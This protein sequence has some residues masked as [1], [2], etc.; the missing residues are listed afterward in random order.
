MDLQD[1][2]FDATPVNQAFSRFATAQRRF[3]NRKW[4]FHFPNEMGEAETNA[5]QLKLKR[6]TRFQ[7]FHFSDFGALRDFEIAQVPG[8]GI[9]KLGFWN[10]EIGA[11]P[12]SKFR[13][14]G[15]GNFGIPESGPRHFE[16]TRKVG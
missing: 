12:I 4:R 8:S 9:S 6:A 11:S 7:E 1:T 16:I 14:R 10:F 15:L 2:K 13:N 5:I 3:R